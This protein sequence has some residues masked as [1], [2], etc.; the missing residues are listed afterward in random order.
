MKKFLTAA[1]TV[2]AVVEAGVPIVP[3]CMIPKGDIIGTPTA[4]GTA[5]TYADKASEFD[6]ESVPIKFRACV[7]IT[8]FAQ[9]TNFPMTNLEI[10][11]GKNEVVDAATGAK[12]YTEHEAPKVGPYP[13][14]FNCEADYTTI[15]SRGISAARFLY[16]ATRITGI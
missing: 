4:A 14:P 12:T 6:T 9:S 5:F 16:D 7:D 11:Y 15:T 8:N 10:I 1:A 13:S 2:G 3:S